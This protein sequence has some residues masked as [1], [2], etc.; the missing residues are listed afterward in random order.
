MF[1]FNDLRRVRNKSERSGNERP[2]SRMHNFFALEVG[3]KWARTGT[4]FR[5]LG[6]RGFP[7]PELVKQACSAEVVILCFCSLIFLLFRLNNTFFVQKRN[8]QR[9]AV[10]QARA[11]PARSVP[12]ADARHTPFL[13]NE[14]LSAGADVFGTSR[15]SSRLASTRLSE[16][17]AGMYEIPSVSIANLYSTVEGSVNRVPVLGKRKR[18]DCHHIE[19]DIDYETDVDPCIANNESDDSG[20]IPSHLIDAVAERLLSKRT[21]PLD[22]FAPELPASN[23]GYRGGVEERHGFLGHNARSQETRDPDFLS[24]ISDADGAAAEKPFQSMDSRKPW[25]GQPS[26][27]PELAIHQRSSS[28]LG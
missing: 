27:R 10:N 26:T 9:G 6:P 19:S 18:R 13:N 28:R 20:L 15:Y 11:V 14:R 25:Y 17:V 1:R 23:V 4:K 22:R 12:A 3:D 21:R 2:F 24:A 8:G 5:P 7:P 16:S